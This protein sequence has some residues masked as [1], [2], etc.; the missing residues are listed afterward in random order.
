MPGNALRKRS[1]PLEEIVLFVRLFPMGNY[2]LYI[3]IVYMIQNTE[4]ITDHTKKEIRKVT[5]IDSNQK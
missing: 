2:R 1:D 4:L 3:L 5:T